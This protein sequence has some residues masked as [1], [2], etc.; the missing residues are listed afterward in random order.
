MELNK[1]KI[2]RKANVAAVGKGG[3]ERKERAGACKTTPHQA[4]LLGEGGRGAWTQI[5]FPSSPHPE[6]RRRF[7]SAEFA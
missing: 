4:E 5:D 6:L 1:T 2:Q 7:L 3:K